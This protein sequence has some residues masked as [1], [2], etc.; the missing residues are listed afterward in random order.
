MRR[1]TDVNYE[2]LYP[3]ETLFARRKNVILFYPII[4]IYN[5][6]IKR[7]KLSHLTHILPYLLRIH[8]K[9]Y[10]HPKTLRVTQ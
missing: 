9:I 4:H 8:Q 2:L 7:L 3:Q 10:F 6:Y 5:N 1:K